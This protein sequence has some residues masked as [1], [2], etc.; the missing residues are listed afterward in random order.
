MPYSDIGYGRNVATWL[1]VAPIL[2]FTGFLFEAAGLEATVMDNSLVATLFIPSDAA[3]D[4]WFKAASLT[5]ALVLANTPLATKLA[6]NLIVPGVALRL[7]DLNSGDKLATLGQETLTLRSEHSDT[8]WMVVS[9]RATASISVP[10]LIADDSIIHV[11]DAVL[12]PESVR[13]DQA[14]GH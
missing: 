3:W 2:N 7:L 10:D 4:A 13:V 11:V 6:R 1:Q 12:T 14:H 5:P 9:A 8:V